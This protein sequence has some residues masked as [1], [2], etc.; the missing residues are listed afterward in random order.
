MQKR[1]QKLKT[2]YLC[3][4]FNRERRQSKKKSKIGKHEHNAGRRKE[5]AQNGKTERFDPICVC[6]PHSGDV[7]T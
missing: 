6:A 3:S 4:Y 1:L 7:H 5:E 2:F